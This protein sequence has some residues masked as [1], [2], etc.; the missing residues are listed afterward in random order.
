MPLAVHPTRRDVGEP[1]AH[2]DPQQRGDR[3][4]E[5]R[6]AEE[7]LLVAGRRTAEAQHDEEVT[8]R[9][10]RR[11]A[12]QRDRVHEQAVDAHREA[13][14]GAEG[15]RQRDEH[16]GSHRDA[17]YR[18]RPRH[19][20]VQHRDHDRDRAGDHDCPRD[21]LHARALVCGT[22]GA[23]P[24]EEPHERDE[25]ERAGHAGDRLDRHVGPFVEQVRR[26]APWRPRSPSNVGDAPRRRAQRPVG[27][28]ERELEADR[29]ENGHRD[30]ADR[31]T[32]VV[33]IER[34]RVAHRERGPEQRECADQRAEHH[35]G[36]ERLIGPV[37]RHED[38]ADT[39][40]G[41]ERGAEH[42]TRTER[43]TLRRSG[44]RARR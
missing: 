39:P 13:L 41:D 24:G 3:G 30:R 4:R 7:R 6:Q 2:G 32:P 22:G 31:G 33:G 44:A 18:L 42:A 5:H 38:R 26:P 40:Y 12:G 1:L 21:P 17:P 43:R 15:Q 19:Q 35:Q 29:G 16:R 14:R 37:H 28:A 10:H 8:R 36:R 9:D 11:E 20:R 27:E 34:R 25:R 23:A